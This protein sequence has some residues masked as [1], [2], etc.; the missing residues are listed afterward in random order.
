MYLIN[1]KGKKTGKAHKVL[2][3]T[4]QCRISNIPFWMMSTTPKSYLD[5]GT[6]FGICV[7]SL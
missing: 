7:S 5:E 1:F 3:L 2:L 6:N 4:Q